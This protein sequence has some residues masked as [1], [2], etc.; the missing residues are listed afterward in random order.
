MG[1]SL[2]PMS[3]QDSGTVPQLPNDQVLISELKDRLK[4][5]EAACLIV[6]PEKQPKTNRGESYSPEVI[7][8]YRAR[9]GLS[10]KDLKSRAV[11]YLLK[12]KADSDAY[13]AEEHKEIAALK[14]KQAAL[15][16][17][18]GKYAHCK[19]KVSR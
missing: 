6:L 5:L 19:P 12:A 7:E 11:K 3:E 18:V 10:D 16:A 15:L 4:I 9:F 14:T 8:S 1:E 2:N 17:F 13:I